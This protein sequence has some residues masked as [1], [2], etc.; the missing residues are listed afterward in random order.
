MSNERNAGFTLIEVV[1]VM[2]I[3]AILAMIAIPAYQEYV[4]R[5]HRVDATAALLKIQN[6]QEK[7]YLDNNTYTDQLADLGIAGTENGYYTLAL[8]DATPAEL[9]TGYTVTATAT[10]SQLDD[11]ACRTFSMNANGVRIAKDAEGND[12]TATCWR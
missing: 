11:T 5:A 2:A 1:V 10:G 6:E 4:R 9:V 12:N 7:Y 3:V 8:T